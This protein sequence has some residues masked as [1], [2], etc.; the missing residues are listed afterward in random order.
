MATSFDEQHDD[1]NLTLTNRI[2]TFIYR[3]EIATGKT[4]M[5]DKSF[6]G[7]G[8]V[9]LVVAMGQVVTCYYQPYVKLAL[10]MLLIRTSGK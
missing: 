5:M 4:G 10:N 9:F 7:R 1:T 6:G 8:P 2:A 3:Y